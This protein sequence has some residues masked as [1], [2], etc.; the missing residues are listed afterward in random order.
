MGDT[1]THTHTILEKYC[2]G[3]ATPPW[4]PFKRDKTDEEFLYLKNFLLDF[5][6]LEDLREPIKAAFNIEEMESLY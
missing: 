5:H 4:V 1:H 3:V 2:F 6:E